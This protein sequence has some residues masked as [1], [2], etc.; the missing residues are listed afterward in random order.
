MNH[1]NSIWRNS[2]M[3]KI[4]QFRKRYWFLSNFFFA[5]IQY[6]GQLW[7]TTEHLFQSMKSTNPLVKE[8]IRKMSRPRRARTFGKQLQ[9]RPEWEAIRNKMMLKV[10]RLKFG[11]NLLL[12]RKLL[13]TQNVVLEEG[14]WWH[15]NYWGNCLCAGC[16][17]IKGENHLGLLL[18]EVRKELK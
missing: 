2:K 1:V 7:K 4:E 3:K 8:K 6:Q 9:L 5:P 13:A 15:D 11:Q 17:N 10:L 12:A 14:N 18:M 16:K